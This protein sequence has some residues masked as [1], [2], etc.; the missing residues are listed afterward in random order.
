MELGDWRLIIAA[1]SS[2]L[3]TGFFWEMWNYYSM[4]KWF[5]TVPYV[6]FGKIFEMP[7]LGFGGYLPFGIIIVSYTFLVFSIFGGKRMLRAMGFE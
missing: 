6:G 7:I 3:F 4:P 1:M 2:A 5:Y